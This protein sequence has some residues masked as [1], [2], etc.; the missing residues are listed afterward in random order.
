MRLTT[1][2]DLTEE[3]IFAVQELIAINIENFNGCTHAA[4]QLDNTRI[5]T[6]FT[7]LANERAGHAVELQMLIRPDSEQSMTTERIT[8][9]VA[10]R[11][12]DWREALAR[13]ATSVLQAAE[14]SETYIRAKYEAAMAKTAE[15]P[16]MSVLSRQ[17]GSVKK[18]QNRIRETL[19]TW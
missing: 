2:K 9:R 8:G 12:M 18:A 17:Y 3:T 13:G 11:I 7:E 14:R 4:A 5:Q 1:K 19:A 6:L 15:G 10:R 16:A